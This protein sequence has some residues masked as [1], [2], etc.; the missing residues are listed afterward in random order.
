MKNP[1]KFHNEHDNS[2]NFYP[3]LTKFG[4][5][6]DIWVETNPCEHNYLIS[7]HSMLIKLHLIDNRPVLMKCIEW[8]CD[9]V[10]SDVTVD[11]FRLEFC[12][13]WAC[14]YNNLRSSRPM[15]TK[16]DMNNNQPVLTNEWRHQWRHGWVISC[17]NSLFSAC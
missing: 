14:E 4:I 5:V 13:I 11:R 8:C 16:L 15:F 9:D 12:I 3:I 7:L 17:I 10:S 1:I 6:D 2:T